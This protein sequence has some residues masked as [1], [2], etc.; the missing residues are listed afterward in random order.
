MRRKIWI[1]ASVLPSIDNWR[2]DC[3]SDFWSKQP[4]RNQNNVQTDRYRLHGSKDPEG[5]PSRNIFPCESAYEHL[6]LERRKIQCLFCRENCR[7]ALYCLWA[8]L[9]PCIWWCDFSHV[10]CKSGNF[11]LP[12]YPEQ[13]GPGAETGNGTDAAVLSVCRSILPEQQYRSDALCYGKMK[14]SL[15]RSRE[16]GNKKDR[17]FRLYECFCPWWAFV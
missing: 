10:R 15:H 6:W 5:H 17:N 16:S 7:K 11:V 8:S 9:R 12:R 13:K 2:V 1:A 14:S 4:D 3:R